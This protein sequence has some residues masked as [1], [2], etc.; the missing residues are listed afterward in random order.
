MVEEMLNI[1]SG[2]G[3]KM[4]FTIKGPFKNHV[5]REGERDQAK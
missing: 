3:P 2:R 4:L 1:H 5:V